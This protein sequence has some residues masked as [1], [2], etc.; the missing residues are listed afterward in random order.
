MIRFGR[1]P[2][3]IA[4]LVIDLTVKANNTSVGDISIS[5]DQHNPIDLSARPSMMRGGVNTS[6][7]NN[8]TIVDESNFGAGNDP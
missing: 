2:F 6:V 4:K 7:A 8:T 3:K 5:E 1:I